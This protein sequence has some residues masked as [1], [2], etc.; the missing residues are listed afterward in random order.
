MTRT[1]I[2]TLSPGSI[3]SRE[4]HRRRARGE[5]TGWGGGCQDRVGAPLDMRAVDPPG[6]LYQKVGQLASKSGPAATGRENFY[7]TFI[8]FAKSSFLISTLPPAGGE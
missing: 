8:A 6:N 7:S 2:S 3:Q 4:C 5:A 1:G